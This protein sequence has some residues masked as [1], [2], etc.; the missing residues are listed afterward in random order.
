M[1]GGPSKLDPSPDLVSLQHVL[2]REHARLREEQCP[3]GTVL[4]PQPGMPERD[5]LLVVRGISG[6]PEMQRY[7]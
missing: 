5:H 6:S 3:L 1:G 2:R 7:E 4:C